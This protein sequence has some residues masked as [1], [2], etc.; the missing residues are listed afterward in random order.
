[1]EVTFAKEYS[2][3]LKDLLHYLGSTTKLELDPYFC[4]LCAFVVNEEK[5]RV[6]EAF[7]LLFEKMPARCKRSQYYFIR[8]VLLLNLLFPAF[9]IV[10]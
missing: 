1:M 7:M 6:S 5:P 4:V 8:I 2:A 10:K 9:I 3:I